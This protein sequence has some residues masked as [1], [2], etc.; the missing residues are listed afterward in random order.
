M[1]AKIKCPDCGSSEIGKGKLSGYAAIH[2]VGKVLSMGSTIIV[3]VCTECGLVIQ[4]KAE[5]P[6]RFKNTVWR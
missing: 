4:M 1:A 2:P 5:K 3:D 6:H